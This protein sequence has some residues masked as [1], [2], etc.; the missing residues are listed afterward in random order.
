MELFSIGG[1][2]GA[3]LSLDARGVVTLHLPEHGSQAAPLQAGHLTRL[4]SAYELDDAP[5]WECFYFVTTDKPFAV[6]PV[7]QSARNLGQVQSPPDRLP[8]SESFAQSVFRL[9]KAV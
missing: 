7:L 3:I 9:R 5:G 1:H 6:D 4:D 8:L 2:Y